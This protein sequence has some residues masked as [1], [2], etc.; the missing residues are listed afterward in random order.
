MGKIYI[1]FQ[2]DGKTAQAAKFVK[3]RIMTEV[4]DCVLMINTL[5]Q[6]YIFLKDM[7]QSPHL[8]DHVKTIAI[9]LSLSNNTLF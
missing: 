8:K 3:P 2:R 9:D 5:K 6:R 7:L 1:C 4:I